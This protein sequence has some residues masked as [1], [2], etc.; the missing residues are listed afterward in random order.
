MRRQ[1]IAEPLR[2]GEEQVDSVRVDGDEGREDGES[3][4]SC[5]F[6]SF[7]GLEFR[8]CGEK[9]RG[10]RKRKREKGRAGSRWEHC[11]GPTNRRRRSN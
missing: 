10:C 2:R 4:E 6:F 8:C 7:S 1:E 9:G 5:F 3:I 11:G